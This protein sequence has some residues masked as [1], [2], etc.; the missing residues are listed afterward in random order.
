MIL[1]IVTPTMTRSVADTDEEQAIMLLSKSQAHWI[2]HL[3]CNRIVHVATNLLKSG[4][5]RHNSSTEDNIWIHRD[6]HRGSYFHSID[7][8]VNLDRPLFRPHPDQP[9]SGVK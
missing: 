3:P 5:V 7:C 6:S 4:L 8:V 9:F 1:N 2:P